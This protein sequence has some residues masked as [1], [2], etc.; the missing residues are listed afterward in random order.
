MK[1]FFILMLLICLATPAL[2]IT[3]PNERLPDPA[4]ET[5]AINLTQKLRCVVCQNE[6]IEASH[7]DIAHDLRALVRQQITSGKTDAEILDFLRARYGDYILLDPPFA[8]RTYL[9]WLAPA[10]IL[11]MGGSMAYASM[12][13]RR[14]K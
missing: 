7:A 14:R 8:S 2:A 9:L 13:R 4:Q 1:K 6:S 11:L 5:R 12:G 3:H 10:L